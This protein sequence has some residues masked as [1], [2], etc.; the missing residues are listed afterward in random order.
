MVEY[1]KVEDRGNALH[2]FLLGRDANGQRVFLDAT[3][4]IRDAIRT[5]VKRGY[6]NGGPNMAIE[7]EKAREYAGYVAGFVNSD[8]RHMFHTR[9]YTTFTETENAGSVV[10]V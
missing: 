4:P 3:R 7:V 5:D 1:T 6:A 9:S 2:L 8:H 10:S